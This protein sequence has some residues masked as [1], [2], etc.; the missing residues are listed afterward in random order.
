MEAG[1]AGCAL[2]TRP[3]STG[4]KHWFIPLLDEACFI[5]PR[6]GVLPPPEYS[7]SLSL[8]YPYYVLYYYLRAFICLKYTYT[9]THIQI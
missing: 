3:P 4:P 6:R 8:L 5:I 2:A 1:A 9:R 7:H